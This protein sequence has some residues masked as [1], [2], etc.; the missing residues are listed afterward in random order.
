LI[1]EKKVE[2]MHCIMLES[3]WKALW[4]KILATRPTAIPSGSRFVIS[5]EWL[6]I[7]RE[8]NRFRSPRAVQN[9]SH[10]PECISNTT[11]GTV[12]MQIPLMSTL[13]LMNKRSSS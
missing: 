13:Q 5:A 8:G 6:T 4:L 7:A 3:S 11:F 12:Q 10:P 9:A 2:T 1:S